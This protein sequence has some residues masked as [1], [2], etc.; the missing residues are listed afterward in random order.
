MTANSKRLQS[1]TIVPRELY[2]S[3]DADRQLDRVIGE[4]GRPG[5]VLVARQ[6]GKTNLLLHMKNTRE[7]MGDAVCYFD[8]STRHSTLRNFFR[9][10]IDAVGLTLS[11]T[12]VMKDILTDR[13]SNLEPNV[14]F[15]LHLR[16]LLSIRSK[17]RLILI[18]DEIDS[19][20]GVQYSDKVLAQIRSMYF[21]RANYPIYEQLT[22][23]LSGVAEPSDLIKDKNISPFNIGE[24]IY[25]E[26]FTLSELDKLLKGAGVIVEPAIVERV[27]HWTSGNP[28]MSWDICSSIEDIQ[29]SGEQ[30]NI[31][32]VDNAVKNLYLTD[33]SRAPIDHVRKLVEADPSMRDALMSIH[34]EKT[35]TLADSLV[36]RLYLSGITTVPGAPPK[37]GNKIVA[38]ALS[39]DWL[40]RLTTSQEQQFEAAARYYN[41]RDFGSVVRVFESIMANEDA[42]E[43]KLNKVQNMQFGH[44]LYNLQ[45]FPRAQLHLEAA[46]A[47]SGPEELQPTIL[48][49]LAST[50]LKNGQ[51]ETSISI[52]EQLEAKPGDFQY[53]SKLALSGSLL[54]ISAREN[55]D[56]IVRL[57]SEIINRDGATADEHREEVTA[58]AYYNIAQAYFS[59]GRTD[60]GLQALNAALEIAPQEMQPSIYLK[61]IGAIGEKEQRIKALSSVVG[62][63]EENLPIA[64]RY[65][66]STTLSF[67]NF[68]LGALIAKALELKDRKSADSLILLAEKSLNEPSVG[69]IAIKILGS[70]SSDLH[71]SELLPLFEESLAKAKEDRLEPSD[72]LTLARASVMSSDAKQKRR[73]FDR[74]IQL[75]RSH[76]DSFRYKLTDSLICISQ[77]TV[78]QNTPK[79]GRTELVLEFFDEYREAFAQTTPVLY[80]FYLNQKIQYNLS[81]NKNEEAQ[82]LAREIVNLSDNKAF[83]DELAEQGMQSLVKNIQE[84]ARNLLR[85]KQPDKYRAIGRNNLVR[86]L[87]TRSGKKKIAKF[88]KIESE[89][90]SGLFELISP[91]I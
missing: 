32:I 51:A 42:M 84:N 54:T 78:E 5:Y 28:R 55:A 53:L 77:I 20:I 39:T 65:G 4:M 91:K 16:K 73:P 18:L 57:S 71:H 6:M 61:M 38:A 44:S 66:S 67:S 37:F 31:D 74:Y 72:I 63:L 75:V 13:Q 59:E 83:N 30:L 3:R 40:T 64:R 41:E 25:L 58:S 15:D 46:K 85:V 26:N 86:Y 82:K 69:R 36:N 90:R 48:F 7:A 79:T 27:F 43:S 88:K 21:A 60:E 76:K 1:L 80:A 12:E 17:P 35:D 10:I 70:A 34:Y 23:V 68:T 11:A 14:E 19:L 9:A 62:L 49:Y 2:V 56:R 8:L 22:Y 52:F 45:K 89:I 29:I 24:K 47:A 33:F 81:I 87:D 50:M